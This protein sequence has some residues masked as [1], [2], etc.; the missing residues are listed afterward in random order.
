M[1]IEE[2]AQLMIL[3][4]KDSRDMGQFSSLERWEQRVVETCRRSLSSFV[5]DM[6]GPDNHRYPVPLA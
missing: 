4:V 3:S 2:P 1:G 6:G 5:A